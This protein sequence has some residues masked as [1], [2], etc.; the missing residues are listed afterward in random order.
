MTA[1]ATQL[2]TLPNGNMVAPSAITGIQAFR[3]GQTYRGPDGLDYE[4]RVVVETVSGM[5]RIPCKTFE[6]ACALRDDLARQIPDARA[7]RAAS[8]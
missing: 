2:I 8:A 4:A 7:P 5:Q 1:H 6:D 3:N